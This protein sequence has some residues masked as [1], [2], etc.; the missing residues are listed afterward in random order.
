MELREICAAALSVL[1]CL[2]ASAIGS[3]FIF[4]SI[5][6]W[7]ADLN[8]P[9]FTPPNW[10]FG[11]VWIILYILMGIA[12]YLVFAKGTKGVWDALTMFVIQL[13]LNVL[14]SILFFGAHWPL[15][16]LVCIVALLCAIVLTIK[17]FYLISK[18]AAY[19][20][21]PYLLWVSFAAMLNLFVWML[22]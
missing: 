20:L 14:W 13:V 21:S 4:P 22:N 17:R 12:A 10:V 16:S 15:L 1:L 3:L 8:K 5:P 19:L 18:A 2:S 6:G 11:P 7:Y 9:F